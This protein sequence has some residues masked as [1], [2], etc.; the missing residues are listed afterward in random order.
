MALRKEAIFQNDLG[1]FYKL[2]IYDSDFSGTATEFTVSSRGFDLEYQCKD[3]TRFTGV[4]P[5]FVTFDIVPR[6]TADETFIEDIRNATYKR[7]QIAEATINAVRAASR[8]FGQFPFPL[9]KLFLI[10]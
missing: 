6:S 9:N 2:N 7:F 1:R 4:I 8:A 5:S 10:S 3:R